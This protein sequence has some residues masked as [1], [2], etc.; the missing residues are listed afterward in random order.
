MGIR[1]NP[2][3]V[4]NLPRYI[5]IQ[6]PVTGSTTNVSAPTTQFQLQPVSSSGIVEYTVDIDGQTMRY[7]NGQQDWMSFVWPSPQGLPG[8]RISAVTTDGKSLEIANF[9]GQFGLEK[10]INTAQRRK[11]DNGSFVMSW[12]MENHTVSLNFKLISDARTGTGAN[13]SG[14]ENTLRGLALPAVIAGADPALRGSL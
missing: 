1:L 2:G 3:F 9:P 6:G 13:S 10:L 7:R 4:N 14:A 8:A 12:T 11:L 5:G